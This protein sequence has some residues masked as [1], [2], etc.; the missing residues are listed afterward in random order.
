M[1]AGGQMGENSSKNGAM[2]FGKHRM[3]LDGEVLRGTAIPNFCE[4]VLCSTQFSGI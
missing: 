2:L 4:E 1:E 3:G